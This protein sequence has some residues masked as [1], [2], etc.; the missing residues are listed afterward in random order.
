M[1]QPYRL[2][3]FMTS[4]RVGIDIG[5]TTAKI[6]ALD[7]AGQLV[8]RNYVRHQARVKDC[9][10]TFSNDLKQL[11]GNAPISVSITGSVGMGVSERCKVPFV[12]EV[13]AATN[14][15]RQAHP[16]TRTMIDIGGE[17]AKV[18]FFNDGH[19]GD[20]R[21]NGNCAGGTGAFIDQMA[22]LLDVSNDE[23]NALALR[24]T[25]IYPMASR[26]GVFSKTD[27]QNLIAKNV[28]REDIA[29]SIFHAVAVQTVTT[30]AHGCDITAPVMF[31]GGP[32]TFLSALQKAFTE[33]LHLSDSD[34]ILPED[35]SIIPAWGAALADGAMET[36][37]AGFAALTT[38]SLSL[39]THSYQSLPA[40]FN[41]SDE[42]AQW[43]SHLGGK[44][45][46][47]ADLK[48][49]TQEAYIG[50]DSGS[51][52]TKIVALSPEGEMLFSFYHNNDGDPISTVEKGLEQLHDKCRETGT[53]L[54]IAGSCSTGY[55]EDLIRAAFGLN[56]GIIET[57]AHY[58]AARSISPE[59]SFILDIGGQ[60]MKA[61]FVDKGVINRI[62]INEACS[63]GCGSFISTFAKSLDYSVDEFA[64]AACSSKAPCDLGTRC[65]VFMNSK[66]KQVLREG[67]TVADIAA[68]LSYSVIKNCLYKVLQ[69]KN[70][71]ELGKHVVVQ[72]G[73][74]R[75]DSIVRALEKLA[76][77]KVN[78][79]DCPELMGAA[80]CALYAI[81]HKAQTAGSLD[82]MLAGAKYTTRR[83]QCRGCENQC[84]VIHYLF[85]GNRRY[86]SGNRCEKI[87]SNQGSKQKAG[88]NA[89]P[90]KYAL[91][92]NREETDNTDNGREPL[93]TM[94]IPRC[95]NMYEDYPFWHTLLNMCGIRTVLS[96]DSNYTEY[97][98]TARCVMSD[99]ICFPAK[100]VHSHIADLERKGVDRIFMPF[101]VYERMEKGHQNSYNCPIVSGYS[102]VVGSSQSPKVPVESPV[103]TFK[104][105]KLLRKQLETWLSKFGIPAKTVHK[106]FTAAAKAQEQYRIRLAEINRGILE[107]GRQEKRLTI[108][109]A[110][111]PYHTD[112]LIQHNIGE[113]AAAM[114]VNVITDDIVYGENISIDD[115]IYLSQWAYPNRI[116][117]AAKWAGLQGS[118]VQYMQLT[119][120]GCGPDAFLTNEVRAT[121][122]RF[123]KNL[124][125]LKIDDVNNVGSIKLR[126]RSLIESLKI[127][128]GE[129]QGNA[130]PF[131]TTPIFTKAER[132]R[133]IIAP[134]FTPF[135]SPLIPSA[136]KVAGYNVVNLP[137]SDSK[138]DDLGLKFS[139]N[140][141]CYPATL[142]VG[143]VIKAFRSGMYDPDTTAVAIT[144][145]GGQ[146]RAS[147]YIALIK[148]A[149]LSSGYTNTP[150]VSLSFGS[151]ISNDQPGFKMPWKKL[152]PVAL[153]AMLYSDVIAK[154]YYAAVVREN[155]KGIAKKLKDEFLDRAKPLVEAS[156]T[157]GILELV[158]EAA[159]K[160][161]SA[162]L[163][164]ETAKVGV[165]GEIFLEFN[166]YAQKNVTE[167]LISK[168]LEVVPP[169]IT[170]FFTQ[171][172]VN[173]ETKNRTLLQ[174]KRMPDAVVN[175][176]YRKVQKRISLF[177]QAAS[178]FRYYMPFDDIREKGERAS[179]LISLNAQFGEGWLIAGE[180]AT[181]ADHGINHVVS[182]QPFGCIANHIIE[183]GIEKKIKTMFPQMNILSLDF[184]SSVSDVNIVNRLLLFIDNIKQAI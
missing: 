148:R 41:D 70:A 173:R 139:N 7:A 182:L 130:V 176:L 178:A 73:T 50:I 18:V 98:H 124:T 71:A 14:Y 143:D 113:M 116:L 58:L 129:K 39:K 84:T 74:M 128:H 171:S 159:R 85:P 146:C 23:L 30:L 135:L 103:I 151:G 152:L 107:K 125:L 1:C 13:V 163:D 89:Y 118:D 122:G 46:R 140:E 37:A 183:K 184:D 92:F 181:Y 78:R 82:R 61:I 106:A 119:S 97:E 155:R 166:P 109:L 175:W 174:R 81:S 15:V 102:E 156:D 157:Y 149:L 80:G 177:N 8:Y 20:L 83:T 51:T 49:G 16:E 62:E 6:V 95:L 11:A 117:K 144:Q 153:A 131:Q 76:D 22:I 100:L 26:C 65:T 150:V 160:F 165:V 90:L 72:G 40:I 133:T 52:T 115:T 34:L 111:R 170:D 121:L 108:M 12:Q 168:N 77:T 101:V 104:D 19:A 172:F 164:R 10:A 154:M 167:W 43:R 180:M 75:N 64:K 69:L 123:H 27:I 114:G 112:P 142:I 66:V 29:A 44:A 94:G 68:G 56:D 162:C 120:F 169:L 88:S 48:P 21:M 79:S 127:S 33:Y 31:C 57:I 60:D 99:N 91:L 38:E 17:D 3:R 35:G 93:F 141:V 110:G 161:N 136:M 5:S 67:A 25:Q 179:K 36:T 147:N 4:Y 53:N 105:P 2:K 134:F 145:T 132:R 45:F 96:A 9:L 158:R 86:Y 63:S 28:P 87:F 54:N 126:V 32:L 137:M 59:V 42:Y 47:R 55:G 24:S 138:S